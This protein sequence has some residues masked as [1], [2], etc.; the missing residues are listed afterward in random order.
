MT[1]KKVLAMIVSLSMLATVLVGCSSSETTQADDDQPKIAMV[2][3]GVFG[4][5]GM[6][7]AMLNG[8]NMFTEETGI[9]VTSVEVTETSDHAINATNFAQQGYDVIIM[10][11]SV[12][13]I[14]PEI[15]E[16]YPD[17]HFILNKGTIDDMDN[18]TSVQFDE[19]SSAFLA[20]A[21]AV[22]MSEYLGD[23]NQIGWVGG[24]RIPDL[25][26]SR[27]AFVA[28]T[29]YMGGS[30]TAV[31]VGDFTDIAK[32]QE[33]ALQMYNSGSYIVQGFAG[34]ASQG[35]YQAGESMPDDYYTMGCATG[36]FNLS[37]EKIV[38]SSVVN[39]D[40]EFNNLLLSFVENGT[41]ESGIVISDLT[42][43]GTGMKYSPEIG[44]IIPQEIIDEIA[45]LEKAVISGELAVPTTEEAYD[46]F[47]ARR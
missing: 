15:A 20:G 39:Y 26:V 40:V 45:T 30:C 41:L 5:Q 4:D 1:T 33:I 42:T 12:S 36:Q 21:F 34:A 29:E 7:D 18:V 28:G 14:I 13:E 17:T 6:N 32:A 2:A 19:G 35:V 43:G 24:M 3:A 10:G 31:Y 8:M 38:A 44:D 27:Y 9:P 23:S 47:T 37:P 46:A 16:Q 25:E 22:L 11:G